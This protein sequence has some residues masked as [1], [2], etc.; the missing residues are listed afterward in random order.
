MIV[1]QQLRNCVIHT[2]YSGYFSVSLNPPKTSPPKAKALG[3]SVPLSET[4]APQAD[5]RRETVPPQLQ[6]NAPTAKTTRCLRGSRGLT[7]YAKR[8]LVGA[9]NLLETKYGRQSLVFH[10]ATLPSDAPTVKL[11]ALKKS[12]QILKY[13]RKVLSR[14]LDKVGLPK[15]DIVV[16]LELQKRGAIHLHTVFV[17]HCKNGKYT[18]SLSQLDRAWQQTLTAVLPVLKTANFSA[19]CNCQRV[20][21]SAGR[22]L[23]KYLSKGATI[24]KLNFSVTWYSIGDALKQ[25]LKDRAQTLHL[26]I[27]RDFNFPSLAQTIINSK[28][29]WCL[30]YF[31]L[32]GVQIRSLFGYFDH[33]ILN[34][35]EVLYEWVGWVNSWLGKV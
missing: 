24:K 2:D 4:T 28:L 32:E 11:E 30:N 13:W 29:G 7:S 17:N 21:K 34:F 27:R 14:L 22:Y 8:L 19:S 16:V 20:K 31:L 3:L 10:T 5:T 33:H 26:P 23:A 12:K 6:Q 25:Q 1:A 18:L 15:D 9:V 35:A